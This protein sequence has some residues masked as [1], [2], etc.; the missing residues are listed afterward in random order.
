MTPQQAEQELDAE[1]ARLRAYRDQHVAA[2]PRLLRPFAWVVAEV[3]Y[4]ITLGL[5]ELA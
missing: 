2:A 3:A 5:E 1:R 4:Q